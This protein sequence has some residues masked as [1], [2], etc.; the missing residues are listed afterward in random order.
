MHAI[1]EL[2]S[3]YQQAIQ[4]NSVNL[5][6][7]SN[8]KKLNEVAISKNKSEAWAQEDGIGTDV[9]LLIDRIHDLVSN[10]NLEIH[11]KSS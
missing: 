11:H 9:D 7:R 10:E 1:G 4:S 2:K 8:A 5:I 3:T 6:A